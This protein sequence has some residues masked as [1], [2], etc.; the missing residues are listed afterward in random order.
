[1]TTSLCMIVKNEEANLP[2]C[3][4]CVAGLFDDVV[5]VDTG[6]SDRTKELAAAAG[7]RVF[8]FPW[9]DSFAAARN[10][11]LS[12]ARGEW[13]FWLDADDRIDHQNQ[14][15]LLELLAGLG[16]EVARAFL[17]WTDLRWQNSERTKQ[18]RHVRLFRTGPQ[19]QWK[20]RVHEQLMQGDEPLAVGARK[21]DVVI[22]HVGYHDP[23]LVRRKNERNLPLLE[24]D[25]RDYPTDPIVAFNLGWTL[26]SLDRPAEALPHLEQ[27]LEWGRPDLSI[28]PQ[29]YG[30]LVQ[31][32]LRL[33]Q[34]V[35]A[36]DACIRWRIQL[37]RD[38]K[39]AAAE[40]HVRRAASELF[41]EAKN[42]Q[43]AGDCARAMPLYRQH[44][45]LEPA[46]AQAHYLLGAACHARKK[47]TEAMASLRR[48]LQLQPDHADAHNHLGAV[49]A[50]TGDRAG[51]AL[52]FRESL[53]LRPDMID[54]R[55]NL[56]R[57]G[58]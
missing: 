55:N 46:D 22:E 28:G 49:L 9:C 24:A 3:L 44:L 34:V 30:L 29:L 51:A 40:E 54:A 11:A 43:R 26:L 21:A 13:A 6:S 31:A 14:G 1:M 12:H 25:Q 42:L 2:A 50:E 27:S 18:V 48:A 36:R 10:A 19:V 56:A 23:Q 17:L 58:G 33:G 39:I 16:S 35:Q 8:D 47:Y 32:N 4:A 53:R 15:R 5:V 38:E 41:A 45:E 20:Y 7:A 37:P 57:L 52:H